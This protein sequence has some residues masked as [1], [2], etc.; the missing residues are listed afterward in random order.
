ML[1]MMRPSFLREEE[2]RMPP[3]PVSAQ[4]EQRK[5]EKQQSK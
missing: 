2:E 5:H 4:R 3:D 1:G